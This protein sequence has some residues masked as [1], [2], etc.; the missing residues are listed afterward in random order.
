MCLRAGAPSAAP[1]P[2]QRHAAPCPP[3]PAAASNSGLYPSQLAYHTPHLCGRDLPRALLQ[4]PP[5][6]CMGVCPVAGRRRAASLPVRLQRHHLGPRATLM[7]ERQKN[8][9][10]SPSVTWETRALES[11][12]SSNRSRSQQSRGGFARPGKITAPSCTPHCPT[13]TVTVSARA[14]PMARCPS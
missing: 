12:G 2:P 8:P 4:A 14:R 13:C 9:A 7:L 6:R 11:P 10:P 3:A 1:G 5:H